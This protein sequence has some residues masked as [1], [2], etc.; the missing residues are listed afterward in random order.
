MDVSGDAYSVTA[1]HSLKGLRNCDDR[2]L[3]YPHAALCI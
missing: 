1:N 2:M 3:E